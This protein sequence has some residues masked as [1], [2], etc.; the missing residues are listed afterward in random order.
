MNANTN[1][2]ARE[3]LGGI[4]VKE[5]SLSCFQMVYRLWHIDGAL[6]LALLQCDNRNIPVQ[7]LLPNQQKLVQHHCH[8]QEAMF[9]QM[10]QKN[11]IGLRTGWCGK[12]KKIPGVSRL[13]INSRVDGARSSNFIN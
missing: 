1:R 2:A 13:A 8:L 10:W 3:S 4:N 7:V 9:Q 12:R 6:R 11:D 5:C